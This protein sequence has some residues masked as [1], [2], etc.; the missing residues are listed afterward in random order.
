MI[1]HLRAVLGVDPAELERLTIA[2]VPDE[3]LRP[4]ATYVMHFPA[5]YCET[6]CCKPGKSQTGT[7]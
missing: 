3:S 7:A 6:R 1:E 5:K 2:F 4:Q